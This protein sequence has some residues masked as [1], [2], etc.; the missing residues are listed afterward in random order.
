MRY[1]LIPIL[2][3]AL[4]ATACEG[5]TTV[6]VPP[7]DSNVTEG[8]SVSGLGE[9]RTEPDIAIISI[10]IEASGS[11]VQE[12]RDKGA[13][14]ANKLNAQHAAET[15]LLRSGQDMARM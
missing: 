10:G 1:L 2:A 14:A 4:F 5:D 15:G 11:T 8:I 12:A 7:Q 3:L 6:N 9:V 13:D